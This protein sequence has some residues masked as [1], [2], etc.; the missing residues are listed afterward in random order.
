MTALSSVADAIKVTADA[1]KTASRQEF[2]RILHV[3]DD[4]PIQSTTKLLLQDMNNN[5]E[6]ES[7]SSV[8]EAF[9]K[10]SAQSFDV[11]VSDFEMPCKNG[12]DLLKELREKNNRVPF[13]LFTG[14]GREEVAVKALNLGADGYYNKQGDPETV[15]TELAHGIKLINE[16]NKAKKALAESEEK[17]KL[18]A[19][20]SPNIIFI[21]KKGK[22]VYANKK[23]HEI[24]GYSREELCSA[25]FSFLTIT[26]PE[27]METLQKAFSKHMRGEEVAPYEYKL[28]T[29]NGLLLDAQI[30]TK[31]IDYEG[32]KAILGVVTDITER[33]KAEI[34]S[35]KARETIR[36]S[37]QAIESIINSTTDLIYALDKDWKFI[38][39][40]EET[41]KRAGLEPGQL[42]GR[43]GWEIF[44]KVVGTP[45]EKALRKVMIER[46]PEE[47]V[48][49]S[50]DGKIWKNNI[51]PVE[52][53][54]TVFVNDITEL[55]LLDN[56]L[57]ERQVEMG[58]YLENCGVA[59]FIVNPQGKYVYANR[60][61]TNLLGYTAEELLKMNIT[62]LLFKED[63]EEKMKYFPILKEKG[64]LR[65][66]LRLRCKNGNPVLVDFNAVKLPNQTLVAFCDDITQ[67]KRVQEEL[68]TRYESLEKVAESM[69]AGLLILGK[70]YRVV[71]S[72][73]K[74]QKIGFLPNQKCFKAFDR[75]EVCPDCGVKKVFEQN[76]SLE[77]HDYKHLDSSGEVGWS[78]LRSTPLKD[79]NGNVTAVLELEIPI[80]ERKKVEETCKNQAE[81]LS[82]VNDAI[83]CLDEKLTID[84]WNDA[85]EK[86]FGW[87]REEA[88]GKIPS[89]LLK[90]KFENS[91]YAVEIESM[92]KNGRWKGEV[93]YERK[94]G[95][96]FM[97]D[98]SATVLKDQ[99]G[100][101]VGVAGVARDI[102]QN[103]K[104]EE[105]EKQSRL[106]LQSANEKLRVVGGLTR[107]DVKNKHSTIRAHTY[108]LRKHTGDY[109]ELLKHLDGID[110]AIDQSEE[111][112]EFSRLYEKI[113][114]EESSGI[115]VG[116]SFT[117]AIRLYPE[118]NKV[119][120][121]N[122]CKGLNVLADSMLRQ[123][124]YN[125]IDN[126]LKHGKKVT[127]IKL[128]Q[129]QDKEATV[130]IYEDN[131]LG[132]PEEHKAKIFS[133][134]TTGGSGLG[135]KMVKKMVEAYGW[136]I[137]ENGLLQQ[138][139]RFE[140][141]LPKPN[142]D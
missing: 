85:S 123:L 88:I 24:M 120:F 52:G 54:V 124:F 118:A 21:N 76:L 90:T 71:W 132:I 66:E 19:D 57:R 39:A 87:T 70:D 127:Q 128:S 79:K 20:E 30:N 130:I 78:Q 141:T 16:K 13:I 114:A 137:K 102:S 73:S 117:E 41:A 111:I 77:V 32:D 110:I 136:T 81:L 23:A 96:H 121:V 58:I 122:D 60:F 31:L 94:D 129:L 46:K 56:Q 18:L 105:Q 91:T 42:V 142:S 8:D 101:V 135:L 115:D 125:L 50:S 72:N 139:A 48:F 140:I 43:N 7:A 86:L 2:V 92:L 106:K 25:E 65:D 109:P 64:R 107:H 45:L 100:K 74:L 40:N 15:Y 134:F 80:T 104:A 69:D 35:K 47:I 84:Y 14:K 51:F 22:V 61:A 36:K 9:L 37:N 95:S 116:I 112:F 99:S 62:Q 49:K 67:R 63:L 75:K 10:L 4:M 83:F 133:G 138:G 131:G 55:T 98:L 5:F 119:L 103:K 11:I 44:P 33:K 34:E 108:L 68:Q 113:G 3:D 26:S 38:Y 126:S 59:A 27:S 1:P 89:D 6:I 29:K 53:G 12:L 17:F 28:V 93:Q 97:V 82:K